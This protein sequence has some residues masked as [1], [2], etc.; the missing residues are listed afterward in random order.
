MTPDRVKFVNT[1]KL[2]RV[3]TPANVHK[4]IPRPI[5]TKQS[6]TTAETDNF[7]YI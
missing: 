4:Y 3:Q 1:P 7:I 5:K 2:I 6:T